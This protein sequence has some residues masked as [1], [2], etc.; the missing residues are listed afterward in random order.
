MDDEGW[1]QDE[2]DLSGSA[3]AMSDKS[4]QAEDEGQRGPSEEDRGHRSSP[5]RY[6]SEDEDDEDVRERF[7]QV[8]TPVQ[9]SSEEL[10]E[11]WRWCFLWMHDFT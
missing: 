3:S 5:S 7:P 11:R 1:S 8:C 2:D 10:S 6:L 9:L 4:E